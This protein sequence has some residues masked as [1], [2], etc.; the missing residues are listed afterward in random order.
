MSKI[1]NVPLSRADL[2]ATLKYDPKTG[3]FYRYLKSNR[4]QAKPAGTVTGTDNH[5]TILVRG[6]QL[7]GHALAWL[8]VKGERRDDVQHK[9]GDKTD[10]RIANLFVPP[11]TKANSDKWVGLYDE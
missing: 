1:C 7:T 4:L 11:R 3:L 9:N 8:Y 5:I 2:K 6:Y 10:N